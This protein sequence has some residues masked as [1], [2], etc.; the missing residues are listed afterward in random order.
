MVIHYLLTCFPT[1]YEVESGG[2]FL[3]GISS[4][5]YPWSFSICHHYSVLFS[6]FSSY[7]PSGF[8]H[9]DVIADNWLSLHADSE[10]D[11]TS[12]AYNIGKLKLFTTLQKHS[13]LA[14]GTA[15]FLN[16]RVDPCLLIVIDERFLISSYGANKY[17]DSLDSIRYK[18]F[19]R[20]VTKRTFNLPSLPQRQS[21]S[22]AS[23]S[24]IKSSRGLVI[25]MILKT[26]KNMDK[27]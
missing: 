6:V 27:Y 19:A 4:R 1:T 11:T 10:C 15:L 13:E 5:Y 17:Y 9:G 8:M 20:S 7:F 24:T 3:R 25:T 12:A 26:G 2:A 14:S 16:K 18:R 23:V 22:T 21:A